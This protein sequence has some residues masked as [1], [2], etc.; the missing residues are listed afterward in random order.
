MIV[1]NRAERIICT[2]SSRQG[3]P[4][5]FDFELGP[6]AKGPPTHWHA[7]GPEIIEVV[8]GTIVVEVAGKTHHLRE[9]ERLE[10]PARAA[11][12]FLNP[13]KT[14]GATAHA[15]HGSRFERALDQQAER[16]AFLRLGRFLTWEDPEAAFMVA[17]GVRL[18]LRLA[19]MVAVAFRV[20]LVPRASSSD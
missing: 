2:R 4:F 17:R 15:I 9:G 16:P 12:S 10:I 14:G 20:K 18:V 11:H 13:S 5:E 19:G 7:E 1:P 6:R 8:S 3:G